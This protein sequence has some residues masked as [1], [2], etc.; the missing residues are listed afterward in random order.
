[1]GEAEHIAWTN[2][3]LKIQR[4][5]RD[6]GVKNE[7]K[8]FDITNNL[9]ADNTINHGDRITQIRRGNERGRAIGTSKRNVNLGRSGRAERRVNAAD[10]D[11]VAAQL[12]AIMG[13]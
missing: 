2:L 11:A 10:T 6:Y 8:E 4:R 3:S 7:F 13:N 1:M 9:G 12:R 5:E